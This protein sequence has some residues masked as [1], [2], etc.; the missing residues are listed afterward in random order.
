MADDLLF[1]FLE[2][3][4]VEQGLNGVVPHPR[5]MGDADVIKHREFLEEADVLER[6][7]DAQ[8]RDRA[9][10]P[11]DELRACKAMLPWVAL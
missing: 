8:G 10:R 7:G 5:I 2:A 9:R 4:H 11:A 6:A 1:F 3:A